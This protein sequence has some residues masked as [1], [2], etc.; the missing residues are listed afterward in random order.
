MAKDQAGQKRD[1]SPCVQTSYG[2]TQPCTHSK[3]TRYDEGH[4]PLPSA[5]IK[6]V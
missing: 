4:S 5:T 6:N 3:G 1:F 2:P